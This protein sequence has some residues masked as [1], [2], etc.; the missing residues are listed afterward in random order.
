[1]TGKQV[2]KEKRNNKETKRNKEAKGKV[3]RQKIDSW[4]E[5]GQMIMNGGQMNEWMGRQTDD[6]LGMM[7]DKRVIRR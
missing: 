4:M 7:C 2:M 3:N 1:M 6:R 5:N